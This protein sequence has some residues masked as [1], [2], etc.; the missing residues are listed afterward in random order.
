MCGG[1]DFGEPIEVAFFVNAI[2][3]GC[4]KIVIGLDENAFD[5][6]AY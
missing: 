1:D 3:N 2:A 6:R 5:L 4:T